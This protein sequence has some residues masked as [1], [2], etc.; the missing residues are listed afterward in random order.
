MAFAE[1]LGVA[2]KHL[3]LGVRELA[4]VFQPLQ[5]RHVFL[6]AREPLSLIV[7]PRAD[8]SVVNID[9]PFPS[10]ETFTR[11]PQL[12]QSGRAWNEPGAEPIATPSSSNV[13][14]SGWTS[15]GVL[16]V[17]TTRLSDVNC[18]LGTVNRL[19]LDIGHGAGD[20]EIDRVVLGDFGRQ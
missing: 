8:L 5:E 2:L 17:F 12:V 7:A 13:T 6:P 15:S 11:Q 3:D 1:E 9:R 16:L 18:T 20:R 10:I 14:S 4:S 19:L